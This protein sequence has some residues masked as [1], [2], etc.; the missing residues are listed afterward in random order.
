ELIVV[1][2]SVS[3]TG[4]FDRLLHLAGLQ[5]AGDFSKRLGLRAHNVIDRVAVV[6]AERAEMLH[7]LYLS[8][9]EAISG[10][11]SGSGATASLVAIGEQYR[12]HRPRPD[13]LRFSTLTDVRL[14]FFLFGVADELPL[15]FFSLYVRSAD[16]PFTWLSSGLAISLPLSAYLLGAL[17]AGAVARPF[18]T[19]VGHRNV[20]LIGA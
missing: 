11:G 14:A 2:M 7:A 6:L 18:A 13:L 12:L 16:N 5:A 15:S 10:A 17:M 9:T 3:L 20:F 8:A 19:R 1:T 4:P